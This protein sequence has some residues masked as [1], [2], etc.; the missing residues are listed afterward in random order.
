MALEDGGSLALRMIG[1]MNNA[2]A[3]DDSI[4]NKHF[5]KEVAAMTV[6]GGKSI[7]C[8]TEAA[9]AWDKSFTESADPSGR[10]IAGIHVEAYGGA[11]VSSKK[12]R[13]EE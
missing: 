11:T 4:F 8:S 13:V 1:L 12:A 5:A 10:A 7:A 3:V 9:L 6:P 2:Y